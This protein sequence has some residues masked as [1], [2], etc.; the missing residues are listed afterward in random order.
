MG[1]DIGRFI[2]YIA[3]PS[4]SWLIA[5]EQYTDLAK[6]TFKDPGINIT[7]RGKLHLG[8][9]LSGDFRVEYASG[10]ADRFV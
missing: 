3:K 4:K 1:Y 5:K 6:V 9:E 10:K 7:Y 2:G 8:A